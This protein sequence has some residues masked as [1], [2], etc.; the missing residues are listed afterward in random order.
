[1]YILLMGPPGAGKGTQSPNLVEKYGIPA[2]STGDMF[3]AAVR[4]HTPLGTKAK[5][6]MDA[7]QLVP[8]DV[9]IGIVKDRL[10]Q[11]DTK[12]GFILDGFPRTLDQAIALDVVLQELGI[13]SVHVI[14]ITME[15]EL[16][17][18][19]ITGRRICNNCGATYHV[20]NLPSKVEGV[21]DKCGGELYQRADDQE[22]TVR[23][24]LEVYSTQ[25]KPLIDYYKNRGLY[26]QIDGNQ[27]V[28]KVFQDI[29]TAFEGNQ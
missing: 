15:P 29:T 17:V 14:D 5:E 20:T 22:A 11:E 3:R 2:I 24:R 19:R 4:D 21:C 23:K 26:K 9:T 13:N 28:K 7:G 18:S 6:Y 27:D 1:M 12:K 16:L 10:A 8:D 25:T